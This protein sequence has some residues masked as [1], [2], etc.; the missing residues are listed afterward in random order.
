MDD[1][2][3]DTVVSVG[4]I[5]CRRGHE[6]LAEFGKAGIDVDVL[7]AQLQTQGTES[8]VKSWNDFMAV[9]SSKAASLNKSGT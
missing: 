6:V 1:G 4:G 9:I 8:I 3:G 5:K 2:I 7:A